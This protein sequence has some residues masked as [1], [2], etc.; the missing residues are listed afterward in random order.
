[1]SFITGSG[2]HARPRPP[3]LRTAMASSALAAT[4]V[5]GV[6][7]AAPAQAAT[8]TAVAATTTT[9]T[10]KAGD[11]LSGIA[12]THHVPGGWQAIARA[13]HLT[14]PYVI[15]PGE[16]LVLPAVA[17]A[18]TTSPFPVPVT[19]GRATQI[20]TVQA[21]GSYA[22]VIAWQKSGTTWHQ[23][24]STTKARVGANGVTDGATRKQG[25]DTTPTGAFTITQGFGVG[26]NPGTQMPYQ[27]VAQDD[28]WVE[29]P[30][31]TYYNQMRT[32]EQGGFPLT[33]AGEHGS[34]DLVN[35]PTQYHNA[36]VINF[37]TAPAVPGRG[38]GIFLHDL[39][40]QAGP[41]AGCVALPASVMTEIIRWINPAQHPVI[42]I[43]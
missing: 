18:P 23:V 1:M 34:E 21:H 11:T 15:H 16:R 42:A 13:N 32:S 19:A 38:A 4:A 39:G 36:L 31:S 41:T 30:S 35:Y 3:R 9:Y 28:W 43:H 27:Q 12:Q 26:A 17:G 5:G 6:L 7:A 22:T 2:R 37:N 25:T 10:V 20:I 33:E 29:D 24:Y 8:T 40:P 14:S